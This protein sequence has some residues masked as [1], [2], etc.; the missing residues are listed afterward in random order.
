MMITIV[1][2]VLSPGDPWQRENQHQQADRDRLRCEHI[3][4]LGPH[5]QPY[6]SLPTEVSCCM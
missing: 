1:V 4:T 2:I 6:A 3:L 5:L